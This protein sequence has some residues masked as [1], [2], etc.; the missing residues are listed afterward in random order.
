MIFHEETQKGKT[1]SSYE[2]KASSN[3]SLNSS[4]S[5]LQLRKGCYLCFFSTY[6]MEAT[7]PRSTSSSLHLFSGCNQ[8]DATTP[9][10]QAPTWTWG[11]KSSLAPPYLPDSLAT[12][13]KM[14]QHPRLKLQLESENNCSPLLHPT[15]LKFLDYTELYKLSITLTVNGYAL[16]FMYSKHNLY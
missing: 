3:V 13:R 16:Q 10:V 2:W 12:T 15:T 7:T 11:Q 8:K 1:S 6:W 5:K 14:L 4:F 9:S